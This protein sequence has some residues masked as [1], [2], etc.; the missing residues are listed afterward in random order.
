[1]IPSHPATWNREDRDLLVE[2]RTEMTAVRDDIRGLKDNLSNKVSFMEMTKLDK[3]EAEK[4]ILELRVEIE[5]LK[6]QVGALQR[7]Q[8]I[9]STL[10]GAAGAIA[11][12]A[13]NL[14]SGTI[15]F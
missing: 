15:H 9:L 10:A 2:L 7:W 13:I 8:I 4:M 11:T 1:M 6:K 5:S 14:F 12:G 3:R